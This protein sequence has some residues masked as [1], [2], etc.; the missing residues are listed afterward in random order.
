MVKEKLQEHIN[1]IIA[2]SQKGFSQKEI[3]EKFE[4]ASSSIGRI[5]RSNGIHERT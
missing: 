4:T 5:L 3:A 2:L 1:E